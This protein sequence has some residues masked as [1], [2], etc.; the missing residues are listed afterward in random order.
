MRSQ[1]RFHEANP[2][3][4]DQHAAKKLRQGIKSF[5]LVGSLIVNRRD[6]ANGFPPAQHGQL[7]IVGGHQ[8]CSQMDVLADYN[9]QTHEND[10]EI[11]IDVVSASASKERELLVFLNNQSAQGFWDYSLLGDLLTSPGVDPLATGFD[12]LELSQM[13]DSGII[14]ELFGSPTPQAA[15]EAPVLDAIAQIAQDSKAYQKQAEAQAANAG[16]PAVAMAPGQSQVPQ[17]DAKPDINSVESIKGRRYD[18]R[19]KT[20]DA[21]STQHILTIVADSPEQL[22]AFMS[23]IAMQPAEFIS[24]AEFCGLL[25]EFSSVDFDS[26]IALSAGDLQES[27]EPT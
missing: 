23:A 26:T 25:G 24:L 2:R 13:L 4:I 17:A 18:F 20:A 16:S 3:G 21:G 15:A 19:D 27:A 7:V 8:R 6:Q 9:P 12:R 5:G 22:E 11:P 14:E 1:L 10:Y